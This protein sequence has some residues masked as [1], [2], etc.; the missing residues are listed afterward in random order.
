[1]PEEDRKATSGPSAN[2]TPPPRMPGY[3]Q[4]L[5]WRG[6]REPQS[7]PHPGEAR[8]D[9]SVRGVRDGR[10]IPS[11]GGARWYEPEPGSPAVRG[12]CQGVR[13]TDQAADHRAAAH[14]HGAGDV[15]G[16]A[17][18]AL[19]QAGG[20]HLPGRVSVRGRRE[21]A[22]HVHRPGHR[23]PDGP[24]LAAAVG[25]RHGQPA[26]V[27]GLRHRPRGRLHAAVRADGQLAQRLAVARRAALLRR[28][29]HDD[30]EAAHRAEHRVGRHR[31]L[32]AG[33]DRLVLGD[34]LDVLGADH[35]LPGD[36]LLD[37]A[38]LLAAVHEGQGRLRARGRADASGDRLQ[39]GRRPADRHL[40]LG[41]GRRLAAA[42]PAWLHR[43]VL[44]GGR[45]R[46]R[47]L[48]AVG[49]AR[50]AEPGEGGGH[51]RQAQGDAPVPLVDHL[52][53]DPLRRR[54]GGPVPA[55]T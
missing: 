34:E 50:A 6:T 30:P 5:K 10:R 54:R 33:A 13:G 4:R 12:P 41:D 19:P 47:R 37:A 55:L 14:H 18:C 23:R 26:R 20:A 9:V 27:P 8:W 48:L 52:C 44:H 16:P 21:R 49:G 7:R 39:Q 35:P 53:V 51:R 17:G 42:H 38:A 2:T 43:L 15:P 3:G 29:L 46:R 22:E 28:R 45:P 32:S 36:V 24:H 31:R 40:Q 1:M 25:D 11:S